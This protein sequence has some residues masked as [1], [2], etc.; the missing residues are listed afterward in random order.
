MASLTF[1]ASCL[2][3]FLNCFTQSFADI[4]ESLND[5]PE[6][7]LGLTKIEELQKIVKIQDERIS[8]LEMQS[9]ESS[10]LALT[11]L[12]ITIKHQSDRIVKL[13]ARIQDYETISMAEEN[14]PIQNNKPMSESGKNNINAKRNLVK[15]GIYYYSFY[16]Y[17]KA[18]GRKLFCAKHFFY[19]MNN[20]GRKCQLYI[21]YFIVLSLYA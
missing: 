14:G 3:M 20:L 6:W 18:R 2:F 17:V 8:M 21:L 9:R 1:I 7:K 4:S 10:N 16:L 11:D 13:E 5:N 15:K 19:S 12:Q